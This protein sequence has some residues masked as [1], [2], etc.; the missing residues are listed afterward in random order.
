MTLGKYAEGGVR[1]LLVCLT[2][3]NDVRSILRNKRQLASRPDITIRPDLS[4][5]ARKRESILLKERWT[6][7]QSGVARSRLKLRGDSQMPAGT[8]SPVASSPLSPTREVGDFAPV[9]SSRGASLSP[10]REVGCFEEEG[11]GSTPPT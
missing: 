5:T 4:P 7:I 8:L 1:P 2:R 9:A 3:R 10:T 11:D 6:L